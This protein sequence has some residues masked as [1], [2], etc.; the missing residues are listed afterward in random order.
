V[1]ATT[2]G[3]RHDV[4]CDEPVVGAFR[5]SAQVADDGVGEHDSSCVP[6]L[7][8]RSVAVAA[9]THRCRAFLIAAWHQTQRCM[10][11]REP[12][13]RSPQSLQTSSNGPTR[14]EALYDSK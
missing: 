13:K 12:T 3:V 9:W 11:R 4:V 10:Y 8:R 6:V 1:V 7:A 2:F 5:E 14:R